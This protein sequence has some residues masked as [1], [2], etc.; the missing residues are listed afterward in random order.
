MRAVLEEE[1]LVETVE[2]I[3]ASYTEQTSEAGWPDMAGTTQR[4]SR[5]LARSAFGESGLDVYARV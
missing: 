1:E 4:V 5:R 2:G 3:V